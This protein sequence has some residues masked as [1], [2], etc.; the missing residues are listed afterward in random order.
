MAGGGG[1]NKSEISIMIES[2]RTLFFAAFATFA[3]IKTTF[4]SSP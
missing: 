4:I 3:V 1:Y 2:P